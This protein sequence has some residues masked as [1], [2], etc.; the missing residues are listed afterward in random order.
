VSEAGPGG[1]RG[2]PSRA[3][4]GEGRAGWRPEVSEVGWLRAVVEGMAAAHRAIGEA[5]QGGGASWR[6]KA[7]AAW[8][9]SRVCVSGLAGRGSRENLDIFSGPIGKTRPTEKTAE[10]FYI[11]VTQTNRQKYL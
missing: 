5:E 1:D 2:R 9:L 11:S 3:A 4:A 8:A 6:W 10:S 7:A